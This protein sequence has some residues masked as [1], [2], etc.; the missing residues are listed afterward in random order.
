MSEQDITKAMGEIAPEKSAEPAKEAKSV[1]GFLSNLATSGGRFIKDTVTGLPSMA[2]MAVRGAHMVANPAAEA[3]TF[4]ALGEVAPGVLSAAG[5]A[6][7]DRYGGMEQI[8]NTLYNDPVGVASDIST[9]MMPAKA[10]LK[11]GGFAKLAKAAG[12][13]GEATNPMRA[14]GAVAE[15][16]AHGAANLAVRTT[17]RPPAAV[18][19]DFGGSKGIADA[20]LKDRVFSEANAQK[21][22]SG[23]VE[24]ADQ[25]LAD[26]QAAGTG[27]VPRRAVAD[28]VIGTP[29]DTAKLR[30]RLGEADQ[31]PE[32]MKMAKDI[33]RKNPKKIPLLDSQAMKRESQALA[34]ESGVDNKSVNKAAQI[35]K[36][37][38]LR[39]G[40][41]SKVPEVGPVN[42]QSQRLI[43]SKLA[44]TAAED[45]PRAL[46]PLLSIL[47]GGVGFAGGGV[48]GAALVPLLMK[49]IDS[50][51]A[52]AMAGI[53]MNEFG[54]GIN[55]QSLRKAALLAQML[56]DE[57]Q[58]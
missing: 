25:L 11:A 46:T 3:G 52:G 57:E 50:P 28:A 4:G 5:K 29:K 56:G 23:S 44:F 49:A 7:G 10:G 37:K 22:L 41:E 12:A 39:A 53:G 48:G 15:P 19:G 47:G 8:K 40:I 2:K 34:Y 51:R 13:I 14:V 42:E 36:A 17:L 21:K 38:A 35:E 20:V 27:G 9:V 58:P 30:A 55:A 31:S 24:R 33:L 6:L 16:I 26:A 45:R 54:K 43:G 32:L 1:G 18:R